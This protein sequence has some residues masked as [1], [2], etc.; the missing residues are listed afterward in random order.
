[1]QRDCSWDG[2]GSVWAYGRIDAIGIDIDYTEYCN[3]GFAFGLELL[4]EIGRE[5]QRSK[6]SDSP[7]QCCILF[8]FA[9][10]L[11]GSSHPGAKNTVESLTST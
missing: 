4:F 9:F 8:Q 6:Q 11:P 5:E 1:M 10:S 3:Y 2:P 7:T